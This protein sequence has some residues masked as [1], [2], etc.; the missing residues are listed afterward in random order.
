M[1]EAQLD[2]ELVQQLARA[3]RGL[4]VVATTRPDGSVHASVV[5]AG[6]LTHPFKDEPCLGF[7][8]RGDAFT[9]MRLAERT[10]ARAGLAVRLFNAK[11]VIQTYARIALIPRCFLYFI[12][13]QLSI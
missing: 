5:N 10:L 2:L 13:N 7:V 1:E 4:A 6:I 3:D 11:S 8:T 12:R 9:A